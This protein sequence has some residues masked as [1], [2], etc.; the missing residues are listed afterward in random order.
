[1]IM[2]T[3]K[4]RY[5]GIST[6]V[7]HKI[8]YLRLKTNFSQILYVGYSGNLL[9]CKSL[10]KNHNMRRNF[11]TNKLTQSVGRSTIS[12]TSLIIRMT[13]YINKQIYSE[14]KFHFIL[15]IIVIKL[16]VNEIIYN[17]TLFW[18]TP[19]DASSVNQLINSLWQTHYSAN[20]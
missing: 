12:N 19:F 9:F 11:S 7:L 1:M 13:I 2:R 15:K 8:I 3:E 4:L 10:K 17:R 14:F 16:L 5:I 18:R 6:E 20:F